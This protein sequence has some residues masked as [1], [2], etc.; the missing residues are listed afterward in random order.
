MKQFYLSIFQCEVIVVVENN[1]S[2]EVRWRPLNKENL[3]KEEQ[4]TLREKIEIYLIAEG[5]LPQVEE[6]L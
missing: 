4:M 3:S 6:I 5:F 2:F 1:D